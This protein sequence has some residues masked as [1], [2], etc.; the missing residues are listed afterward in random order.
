MTIDPRGYDL[1]ELRDAAD[2]SQS[3][4]REN[5]GGHTEE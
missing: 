1:G 2:R 4:A 3:N 5:R